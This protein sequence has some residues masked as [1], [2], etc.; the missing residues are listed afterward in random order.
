V[1][2]VLVAAVAATAAIPDANG[3]IHGCRNTKS[4]ALRVID[5]N[6]GQALSKDETALN[7][8]AGQRPG[9]PLRHAHHLDSGGE[10]D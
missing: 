10:P 5:A 8:E 9:T 7:W 6:T 1:L 2:V 3:V 4:G